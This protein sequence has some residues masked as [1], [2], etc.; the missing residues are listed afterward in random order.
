[1]AIDQVRQVLMN[2]LGLTREVVRKEALDIIKPTVEKYINQLFAEGKFDPI[3]LRAVDKCLNEYTQKQ[4]RSPYGK[5]IS[6]FV[7]AAAKRAMEEFV[8]KNIKITI[9]GGA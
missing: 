5:H 9:D 3:I 2:E 6:D 7:Y 8:A 4:D 1:M